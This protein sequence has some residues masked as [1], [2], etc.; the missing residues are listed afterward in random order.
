MGSAFANKFN[1]INPLDTDAAHRY[2]F[3]G[4]I[5][6]GSTGIIPNGSSGYADTKVNSL[7]HLSNTNNHFAIYSRSNAKNDGFHGMAKSSQQ[8]IQI[9]LRG[10]SYDNETRSDNGD[11]ALGV[12]ATG[13]TS[14]IG[15]YINNRRTNTSVKLF[16][17]GTQLGT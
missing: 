6:H 5:T 7:S 15:F 17:N 3:N 13:Q 4:G 11:S 9:Y 8:T 10:G 12:V 1:L 14:S 16:K 2:V